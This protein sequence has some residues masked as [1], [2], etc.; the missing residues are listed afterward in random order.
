[1]LSEWEISVCHFYKD[2]A[3]ENLVTQLSKESG[4]HTLSTSTRAWYLHVTHQR[5]EK[6]L[7]VHV[8]V[9]HLSCPN[10]TI[11]RTLHYF[12]VQNLRSPTRI[13]VPLYI[14]GFHV[15]CIWSLFICCDTQLSN[16]WMN[17]PLPFSLAH[18]L[19]HI[20]WHLVTPQSINKR[21]LCEIYHFHWQSVPI[22]KVPIRMDSTTCNWSNRLTCSDV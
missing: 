21:V 13:K 1:M 14:G 18:Q 12:V 9:I 20:W 7:V 6:A 5:R 22:I 15:H 17:M 3:Q 2:T 8:V 4:M 16:K 19:V 11:F 10:F